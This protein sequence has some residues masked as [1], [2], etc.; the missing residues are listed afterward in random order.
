LEPRK[1][2]R[3]LYTVAEFDVYEATTKT[4]AFD[5]EV[6][7]F[8]RRPIAFDAVNTTALFALE[9]VGGVAVTMFA[10]FAFPLLSFHDVML[11]PESVSVVASF[12]SS[13][14]A[15]PSMSIGRNVRSPGLME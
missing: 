15:H 8:P 11:D 2:R 13:H 10:L 9:Y 7:M 12:A 3:G 4:L 6:L 1:K 14:N 5:R